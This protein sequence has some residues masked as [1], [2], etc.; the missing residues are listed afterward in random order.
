VR[1]LLAN[2]PAKSIFARLGLTL[3]PLG[4]LYIAATLEA[5]GHVVA[6]QDF[7]V[8]G[9][10][11]RF[12][13]SPYRVVG[14]TTDTCRS[15]LAYDLAR[16]AKEAG[17]LVVIGGPHTHYCEEEALAT[18][19]VDFVVRGEGEETMA[20]L[21]RVLQGGGDPRRVAGL[22][23]AG[24]RLADGSLEVLRSADRPPPADLSALPFPA[25][26]LVRLE[27]YRKAQVF[28]RPAATITTSRG[29]PSNC[30]FCAVPDFVGRR[31]R[32]RTLE[33]V[34][35]EIDLL[36][37]RHG[38]RAL[39][40]M[41]DNFTVNPR[42]ASSIAREIIER[43]YD[44]HLWLFSR[45]DTIVRNPEMVELLAR[46]GTKT[47]F[48]GIESGR[49]E[50]LKEFNKRYKPEVARQAVQLLKNSGIE[51]LGAFILGSESDDRKTIQE[52]V[53]FA[54]DLDTETAQ[55]SILTPF[56]GTRLYEQLKPNLK[57]GDW[58]KFDGM[59][60][61]F[62][63]PGFPGRTLERWLLKANFHFYFRSRESVGR[64]LTFLRNRW[65][66]NRDPQQLT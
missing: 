44:L 38:Y 5:E 37:H 51:T 36:Y 32:Y 28:G 50:T 2:P 40:F 19:H 43:E 54:C 23:F 41:D 62:R 60:L 56:P 24:G 13:F 33:N 25:R 35:E 7:A 18:G 61:V 10:V 47:I 11:G 49:E 39:C 17:A 66:V 57:T 8:D 27:S 3:P 22:S 9:R 12:D 14:L 29:C 1:V 46:A 16:R 26:H 6:V 59:N 21:L 65:R 58:S 45:P 42:W 53:D 15:G 20:E 64:F 34:M 30:H 31:L 63:H 48:M 52:T 55:F 4:L